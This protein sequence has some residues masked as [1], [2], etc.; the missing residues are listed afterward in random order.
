M[1]DVTTNRSIIGESNFVSAGT[2]NLGDGAVYP[3]VLSREI[4]YEHGI[5]NSEGEGTRTIVLASL[6]AGVPGIAALCWQCLVGADPVEN[7]LTS[8]EELS[9][10]GAGCG[11]RGNPVLKKELGKSVFQRPLSA[12]AEVLLNVCTARS[13]RPFVAGWY[14]AEVL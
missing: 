7:G 10:R 6:A 5:A 12:L 2:K 11:V 9:W 13:A 8:D 1:I 4:E 3:G 14:G